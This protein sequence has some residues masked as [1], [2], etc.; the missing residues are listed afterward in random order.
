MSSI[1]QEIDVEEA[2]PL[3]VSRPERIA[4]KVITSITGILYKT[5]EYFSKNSEEKSIQEYRTTEDTVDAIQEDIGE[6]LSAKITYIKGEDRTETSTGEDLKELC[7]EKMIEN[8]LEKTPDNQVLNTRRGKATYKNGT[9]Y[10]IITENKEEDIFSD[11]ITYA[12]EGTIDLIKISSQ[13]E[14]YNPTGL[15]QKIEEMRDFN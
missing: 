8:Y 5:K 12:P 1:A 14:E 3:K 6:H 9:E 15:T 4:A 13:T 7:M 10:F 2:P 11:I